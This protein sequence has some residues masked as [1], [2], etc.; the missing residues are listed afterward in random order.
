MTVDVPLVVVLRLPVCCMGLFAFDFN[1][2]AV[3]SL[4]G[5][6]MRIPSL[7]GDAAQGDIFAGD[8]VKRTGAPG[9]RFGLND[10]L[11][12]SDATRR[13]CRSARMGSS[14]SGERGSSGGMII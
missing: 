8:G 12:D 9:I 5:E 11:L 7:G 14:V 4:K 10:V 6:A 3:A 2:R 13:S 1:G